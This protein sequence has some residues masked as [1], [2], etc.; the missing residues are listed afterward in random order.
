MEHGSPKKK[1]RKEAAI[2]GSAGTTEDPIVLD[3]SGEEIVKGGKKTCGNDN[4]SDEDRLF[5]AI[6]VSTGTNK[7]P[8]VLSSS[9]EEDMTGGTTTGGDDVISD[10]DDLFFELLSHKRK[11]RRNNTN[12]PFTNNEKLAPGDMIEYKN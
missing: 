8:I 1:C 6:L 7:D 9:G 3:S 10:D 11:N 5:R 4:C 2:P 12:T